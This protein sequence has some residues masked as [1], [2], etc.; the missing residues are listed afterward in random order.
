MGNRAVT[1][2]HACACASFAGVDEALY[3][4][5]PATTKARAQIWHH[6]PATRRPRHFHAEPELNLVTAGSGAF[7]MGEK[8]LPVAAGDLLWWPT[9][10]DRPARSH[11]GGPV[12]THGSPHLAA[13][14][15]RC[16]FGR[17]ATLL[18]LHWRPEP[19]GFAGSVAR[20]GPQMPSAP[21]RGRV[22]E[23]GLCPPEPERGR[24]WEPSEGSHL[25]P[26]PPSPRSNRGPGPGRRRR[27]PPPARE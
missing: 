22:G 17:S 23:G 16:P 14:R 18:R 27:T 12:R 15:G 7:G 19:A 21:A 26:T 10:R 9:P 5:F 20:V 13:A 11:T 8:V 3:Q 6:V 4:P 2:G 25:A 1:N 24:V